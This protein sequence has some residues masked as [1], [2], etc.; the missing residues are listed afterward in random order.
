MAVIITKTPLR[1]SFF[2]GGSDW[3]AY[4]D[5]HVGC[6]LSCTID[7]Y[8][9]V[10]LSQSFDGGV[11]VSYSK[12]ENVASTDLLKHDRIRE[13]LL[14]VAWLH[15]VEMTI[16]ADVPG[17][18]SGL[19]SSSA[20][21][22]GVLMAIVAANDG[23]MSPYQIADV[24]SNTE[25]RKC[26]APIGRQDQYAV[27]LG[28]LRLNTYRGE[29]VE[30]QLLPM[31][32]GLQER[33]LLFHTGTTRASDA[34]L[35]AGQAAVSQSSVRHKLATLADAAREAAKA[36]IEEDW[37]H[38][39]KMLHAAWIIKRSVV[40]GVTTPLIDDCYSR[41]MQAGALG[42]KICGAGGGGFLLVFAEPEFHDGIK[43]ALPELKHVPINL[44]TKGSEVVYRD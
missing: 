7:K 36:I 1:V 37:G 16:V 43:E 2:G 22:V 15:G 33:L 32:R 3:P 18:G 6:T 5:N 23:V 40:E 25:I 10:A 24:A 17:H 12:T 28:G 34:L 30:S 26:R 20:L 19:G 31:A 8:I 35:A 21:T 38:F 9:Y 4:C 13:C 41:A 14:S 11:R 39:G 44:T 27:A 42:G 29:Q